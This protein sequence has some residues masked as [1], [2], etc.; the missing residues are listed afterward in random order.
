MR[1]AAQLAKRLQSIH[2]RHHHIKQNEIGFMIVK[3]T[4][5]LRTACDGES[6]VSRA[7]QQSR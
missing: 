7:S 1:V 5:C 6:I 4:D 3:K 2:P